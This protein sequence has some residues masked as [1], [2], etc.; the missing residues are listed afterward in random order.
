MHQIEESLLLL[1]CNW[2][3]LT[4]ESGSPCTDRACIFTDK[5]GWCAWRPHELRMFWTT[6]FLCGNTIWC[7]SFV[8][9]LP[10]LPECSVCFVIWVFKFL[11]YLS[12]I[13]KRVSTW[14][15]CSSFSRI[16][17]PLHI[18]ELWN[19]KGAWGLTQF[20]CDSGQMARVQRW[21]VE[22]RIWPIYSC[23]RVQWTGMARDQIR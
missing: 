9:G 19:G 14:Y 16:T 18:M 7:S 17:N 12:S 21:Y 5:V 2:F 10:N 8:Y 13:L 20:A 23:A 11:S 1:L 4:D 6:N 22:W 3:D 15:S